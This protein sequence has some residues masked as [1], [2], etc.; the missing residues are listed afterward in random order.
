MFLSRYWFQNITRYFAIDWSHISLPWKGNPN[1]IRIA[2]EKK[3]KYIVVTLKEKNEHFMHLETRL[4]TIFL[5]SPL[6]SNK[7]V[8]AS[9]LTL[10]NAS[11]FIVNTLND[12]NIVNRTRT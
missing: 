6:S 10:A 2:Q 7:E 3:L 11:H 1:H 5:A 12:T 9:T 8:D 4:G